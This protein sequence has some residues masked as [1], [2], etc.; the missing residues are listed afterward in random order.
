MQ[1]IKITPKCLITK[2]YWVGQD[3]IEE[4]NM[5]VSTYFHLNT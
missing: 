5:F 1:H 2:N 4:K 3:L